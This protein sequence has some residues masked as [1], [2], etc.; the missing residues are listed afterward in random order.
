MNYLTRTGLEVVGVDLRVID[1]GGKDVRGTAKP[2]VR[3]SP[4]GTT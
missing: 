3:S 1:V 2:L 4:E